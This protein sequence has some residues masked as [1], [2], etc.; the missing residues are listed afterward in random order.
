MKVVCISGKAQHGKDTTANLLK[1]ELEKNEKAVLIAHYA[2]LLKYLCKQYFGWNGEKDEAGMEL[3]QQVGT[4]VIRE[5]DPNYWVNFLRGFLLLFEDQW[6]YVLI[7][8]TRFPNEITEMQRVMEDTIHVRVVRPNF[9]STLSPEQQAHPSETALD[10]T[11]PDLYIHNDD[12]LE[13]LKNIV[14]V[15]V[16]AEAI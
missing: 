7:P 12:D 15:L 9:E 5:Q 10:N 3:L 13:K 1:E 11:E 16:R 2:D 6:D 14:S 8:D 4:N